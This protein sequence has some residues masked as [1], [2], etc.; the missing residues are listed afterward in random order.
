MQALEEGLTC[1]QI[2]DKY[3]AIHREIYE[4][5][6]IHFDKFGRTPTWQQTEIAQVCHALQL[7]RRWDSR[8]E[9]ESACD[10]ALQLSHVINELMSLTTSAGCRASIMCWRKQSSWWSRKASSSTVRPL[11]NSWLTALLLGHAQSADMRW[12][13]PVPLHLLQHLASCIMA[14]SHISGESHCNRGLEKCCGH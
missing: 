8:A 11:A 6:D 5:F 4:W 1:Q 14:M 13:L 2:C 10:F 9:L 7:S 12:A 3:N